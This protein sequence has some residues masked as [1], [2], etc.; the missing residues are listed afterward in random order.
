MKLLK[1]SIAT[2]CP[3]RL[4]TADERSRN[5]LGK[6]LLYTFDLT[7]KDTIP[8]V[9]KK[10]GLEDILECH[11]RV[12]VLEEPERNGI[13]FTPELVPG[14]QI[15]YPGFPSLN[16]LPIE[17][18]ELIFVGLNCF[19][20]ASKYPTMVLKLHK[21]PQLPPISQLAENILGKS[22]YINWPMMHE[23]RVVALSDATGEIRT[24]KNKKV[25]KKF[26]EKE[27]DQWQSESEMMMQQYLAG[28]GYPGSGGV[29][30]GDIQVRLKLLPLQ[31]M[32]TN[33]ANGSTKKCFGQEE[34]EVP[35]QLCLVKAPAPDPR[36]EERG[37]L[38]VKDRFPVNSRVILTKG[39]YRGCQGIV[40]AAA[41]ENKVG[42]K[43]SI[44][45]PEPPFGLAI[46]RSVQESYVSSS[47]AAKILKLNPSVF[48]KITGSL[49][50]DP[51]R[52]DLGLNLKYAEGLYVVGYT[53]QKPSSN[54]NNQKGKGATDK[55][56]A[57]E[58]GDSLLVVGSV[59]PMGGG[60]DSDEREERIQWEYSPKAIKLISTYKQKFPQLFFSLAKQVREKKH[61]ATD[62]FGADG[63]QWLPKIRE[64][65]NNVETAKLP[66]SPVSTEA[67]PKEAVLAAQ[68]AA[69]V[70]T[71]TLRKGGALKESLVKIPGS[72]LY[73]EGSTGA[74]DVLLASDINNNE[75]PELG[76]RIVNLC[77][78]GIPF[79]LRGTVVS[80][81]EAA[82]GCVEVVMDEEF[83]G[84]SSLQGTCAAFR[85]KLCV[86]AHLLKISPANSKTL[87]DQLIPKGSGKSAADKI[88]ASIEKEARKQVKAKAPVGEDRADSAPSNAWQAEAPI[89]SKDLER[90]APATQPDKALTASK[91]KSSKS[92]SPVRSPS[93]HDSTGRGGRQGVWREAQGPGERGTGFEGRKGK[94][95][96][97]R[98]KRMISTNESAG[99]DEQKQST[100]AVT[101][102]GLKAV[103]GVS[104]EAPRDIPAVSTSDATAGLKAM[105]GVVPPPAASFPP[106][107][108]PP[109]TSFP[110]PTSPPPTAAEKL[111]Q[112]MASKQPNG[113]AMAMPSASPGFNFTYVAAGQAAPP[114]PPYGSGKMPPT[115]PYPSYGMPPGG[116]PH[117]M[118]QQ[119]IP[120]PAAHIGSRLSGLSGPSEAEF[121]PFLGGMP[122]K[123]TDDQKPTPKKEKKAPAQIVPSVVLSK[124]RK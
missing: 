24:V 13:S 78:N 63:E 116:M 28:A 73:R 23:A 124:A 38:T 82:S 43:V 119:P 34:A 105:L 110:Q 6:V 26:T 57:W 118:M 100:S 8:S 113:Q 59:R 103:L 97:S 75:A 101:T 65:L 95:G 79:G 58:A 70:R 12:S 49:K 20:S 4:L 85:G 111:L 33:P 93:R 83:I 115:A 123:G 29:H 46:A 18:T 67:L 72:A 122:A 48:G 16:V 102:A 96:L 30:I 54:G 62:L 80:I 35:L 53:R 31:G 64:W 60:D 1:E 69:D 99:S 15:P 107:P 32:K 5:S 47:D 25:V 2:L 42:V 19:G 37:P 77:A 17:S 109:R 114:A 104:S 108:P 22:L 56:K 45:Q 88:I 106:P 40:I 121:P 68:R 90:S 91:A 86:W 36:F 61:T 14:T 74:T 39:K 41:D 98:W 112:L 7:A 66:R 117:P 27:V 3:D 120:T 84:G 44:V 87:V 55:S 52:Y 11:S 71:A 21:M 10:I 76:D 89:A 94:S 50:V 51:G 81:H 9:N 92:V